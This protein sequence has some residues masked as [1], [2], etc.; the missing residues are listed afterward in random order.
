MSQARNAIYDQDL[1]SA[2]TYDLTAQGDDLSGNK[3][4]DLTRSASVALVR[5]QAMTPL[6]PYAHVAAMLADASV[7]RRALRLALT[8]VVGRGDGFLARRK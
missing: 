2:Q 6:G 3:T 1:A 4:P 5:P 8:L 7:R